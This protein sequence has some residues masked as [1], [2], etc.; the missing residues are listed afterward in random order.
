MLS[1][2]LKYAQTQAQ[3]T[4]PSFDRNGSAGGI[5]SPKLLQEAEG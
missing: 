1:S 2:A 5:N 3:Q 4:S